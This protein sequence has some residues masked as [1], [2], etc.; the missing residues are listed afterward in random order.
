M[1]NFLNNRTT[2]QMKAQA[3]SFFVF[4][5]CARPGCTKLGEFLT[6]GTVGIFGSEHICY[7]HAKDEPDAARCLCHRAAVPA[8]V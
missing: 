3:T 5:E 1:K 4:T 8:F 2:I 6:S 7:E